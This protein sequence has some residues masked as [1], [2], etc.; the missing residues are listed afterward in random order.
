MTPL[1]A[2]LAPVTDE[3]S[4]VAFL[5]ALD[6]AELLFDPDDDAFEC[7]DLHGLEMADLH[8]INVSM[9]K[10]FRYLP[11]PARTVLDMVLGAS[12]K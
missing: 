6:E 9:A 1:P 2:Y 5:T 12:H 8:A 4:A 10:C 3:A 7:L 11:D